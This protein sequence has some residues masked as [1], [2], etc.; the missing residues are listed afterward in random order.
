MFANLK[1]HEEEHV[2]IAYRGA[3]KLLK[4]LTGLDVMLAP[5]KIADANANIQTDQDD[6]DSEAKTGHGKNDFQGFKKVFLDTTAD[7]PPAKP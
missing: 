3:N 4:T 5:Q 2:A 7:P 1:K 6:F